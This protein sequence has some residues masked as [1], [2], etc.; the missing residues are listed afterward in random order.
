MEIPNEEVCKNFRWELPAEFNIAEA[1][2]DRWAG[3]PAKVALIFERVDGTVDITT[4]RQLQRSANQWAN[5]LGRHWAFRQ[6]SV[7]RSSCRRT[8]LF[9]SPILAVGKLRSFPAPWRYSSAKTHWNT[10]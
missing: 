3:D 8:L 5:A 7:L 4:Y 9:R 10:A 6:A 1:V 2:C